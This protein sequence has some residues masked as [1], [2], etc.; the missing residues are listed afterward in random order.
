M[1]RAPPLDGVRPIYTTPSHEFPT[2]A[3]LSIGQRLALLASAKA[4][5]AWILEDDYD[6]EYH[7]AGRPLPALQG[8]DEDGRFI[9]VGTFSKV[10]APGILIDYVVAPP[11]L[12][13]AFV[14]ARVRT[15]RAA[16]QLEQ[17]ALTD[18]M[19]DGHFSRH[20]RRTRVLHGERQAE[21]FRSRP[22]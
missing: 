9:Y 21:L 16:P 12:V 3:T 6:G 1:D 19:V 5:G 18:F 4:M 11:S 15:D 17:A 10:L 14:T 2:G 20:I 8:L 13:D 7:Y 22:D